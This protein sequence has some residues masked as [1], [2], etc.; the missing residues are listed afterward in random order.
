MRYQEGKK[1]NKT[2]TNT[3]RIELALNQISVKVSASVY[4]SNIDMPR[5]SMLSL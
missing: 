1:Q 2:N 4:E 3:K 5:H